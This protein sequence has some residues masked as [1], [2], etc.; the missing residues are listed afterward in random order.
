MTSHPLDKHLGNKVRSKRTMKGM[1]QGAL[2]TALGLTFQQIQKYEKGTNRISC[3]TLYEIA[4]ILQ[5]PIPH[6][7]EEYNI[8]E[9]QLSLNEEAAPEISEISNKEILSLVRAYNSINDS[10]VRK[11][12]VALVKSLADEEN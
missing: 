9:Q 6:F 1:S 4:N 12:V 10:G 2:G 5:T 7:F 11:K 3:S 8:N